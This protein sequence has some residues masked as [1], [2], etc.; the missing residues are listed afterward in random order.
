MRASC[1][2]TSGVIAS[3]KSGASNNGRISISLGPG[4]ALHPRHRL[5]HVADPPD[6]EAG[7]QLAGRFEWPVGDRARGAV[8]RHPLALRGRLQALAADE[9]SCVGQLLVEPAHRL[10]ELGRRHDA[11][12]AVLRRPDQ[13][14]HPHG[15]VSGR[16]CR[17]VRRNSSRP[18]RSGCP[19]EDRRQRPAGPGGGC[20][21]PADD[22]FGFVDVLEYV[23]FR[24]DRVGVVVGAVSLLLHVDEHVGEV[25]DFGWKPPDV[26]L[27]LAALPGGSVAERAVCLTPGWPTPV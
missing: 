19:T 2:A 5:V 17:L 1:S 9:D 14:H 10:E 18:V 21:K 13:H 6:P 4:I 11:R 24:K 23:T 12:L 3:P 26:L 15:R 20:R 7:D 22:G 27:V 8:E 25:L 16:H